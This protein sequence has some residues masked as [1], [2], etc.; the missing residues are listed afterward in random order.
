MSP[1]DSI[2]LSI[3]RCRSR[4]SALLGE[5]AIGFSAPR[6]RAGMLAPACCRPPDAAQLTSY[7]AATWS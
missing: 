4:V 7:F 6:D 5:G 2:A 3:L 1:C